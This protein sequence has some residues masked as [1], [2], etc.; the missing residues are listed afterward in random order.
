M[1]EILITQEPS[2][3][4]EIDAIAGRVLTV[5]RP[6]E[7]Y[8]PYIGA[9]GHWWIAGTDSGQPARGEAGAKGSDGQ[10]GERGQPGEPGE[11]GERGERGE[12]GADGTNG[13]NAD[14][15]I[16]AAIHAAAEQAGTDAAAAKN[17]AEAAEKLSK[18]TLARAD[19]TAQTLADMPTV[20][21][22]RA[23]CLKTGSLNLTR[24]YFPRPFAT[25]PD[26]VPGIYDFGGNQRLVTMVGLTAE[27]VD[28]ITNYWHA[29]N[30][31][32]YIAIGRLA[33]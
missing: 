15:A 30:T 8:V 2:A 17:A 31:F 19:H 23:P 33:D 4:I 6:P 13:Q 1:S 32:T 14:P 27:Y 24:I 25:V 3:P 12:P 7:V 18:D 5:T 16:V 26:V 9:N 22:G 29:G 28:L 21:S 10:P 20:I 11:R